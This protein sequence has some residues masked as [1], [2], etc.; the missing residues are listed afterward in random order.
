MTISGLATTTIESRNI[1]EPI[2]IAAAAGVAGLLMFSMRRPGRTPRSL[3]YSLLW[4]LGIVSYGLLL[5]V[6][7]GGLHHVSQTLAID[8]L[9]NLTLMLIFSMRNGAVLGMNLARMLYWFAVITAFVSAWIGGI[10]FEIPPSFVYEYESMKFGG[11]ED[12]TYSQGISAFYGLAG[13]VSAFLWCHSRSRLEMYGFFVS[14]T[15]FVFLSVLGGARG[16]S[17]AAI[18]VITILLVRYR[19]RLLVAFGT[20]VSVVAVVAFKSGSL[21][22]IVLIQRLVSLADDFGMRDILF[23][24]ALDLLGEN[25]GCMIAGC[26]FG[27]FQSY[28]EYDSSYYPHNVILEM[29]I[30]IG[31]PLTIIFSVAWIRGLF[32]YS[33]EIRNEPDAFIWVFLFFFGLSLKSGT[34]L[35]AWFFMG[36][37]CFFAARALALPHGP[38]RGI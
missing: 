27:Y 26:G 9:L 7:Y 32:L 4:Y 18:A 19:V 38:G 24:K 13:V 14:T 17:V 12:L 23:V 1:I 16:E 6:I 11:D 34:L 36:P 10:V 5:S 21:Q 8:L 20:A 29:M 3:V 37:T 25:V 30:V 15:V 33:K 22:D 2:R 31:V 35:S 28:Y